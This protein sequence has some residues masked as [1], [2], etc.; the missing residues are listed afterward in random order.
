MSLR[1]AWPYF[2]LFSIVVSTSRAL[3]FHAGNYS[4][5]F[6]TFVDHG[7]EPLSTVLSRTFEV[8]TPV[9]GTDSQ[10]FPLLVFAH[11]AAGGGVTMEIYREHL[12][13]VASFGFIVIAP[14]S[15]FMGCSGSYVPD[16]H[17][18]FPRWPS[19]VHE[20]IRAIKYAQS[21]S[22]EGTEW[23]RK[24]DWGTGVG[25]FAHSMGGEAAVQLAG[26]FAS[27]YNVKAV[28]CEHCYPCHETRAQIDKPALFFTGNEDFIVTAQQV[29][30]AYTADAATPKT[31]ANARG[32]GHL[33]MASLPSSYNSAMSMQTA[34]FMKVWLSGDKG[35]F[36]D[37]VY[38]D[39]PNSV[40]GYAS[41]VE[42][43]HD[44]G[45]LTALAQPVLI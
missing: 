19:F 8:F 22:E 29:K 38:G 41:M 40:C 16:W 25:A 32:R 18:C 17:G 26:K 45:N 23:A 9:N 12:R 39:G 1:T 30:A 28:V 10:Q 11:G 34:A 7:L 21:R 5:S 2:H 24:I 20:N 15:C 13:D 6:E 36:H 42:C 14:S 44:L 33:E 31:Y 35:Y 4:V 27:D 37:I 3:R 43:E